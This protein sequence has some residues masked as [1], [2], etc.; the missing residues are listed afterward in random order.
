MMD[1]MTLRTL[2]SITNDSYRKLDSGAYQVFCHAAKPYYRVADYVVTSA[3]SGPS[4]I[5]V[6]RKA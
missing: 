5:L 1:G 2:L 4:L 3:V 6:P